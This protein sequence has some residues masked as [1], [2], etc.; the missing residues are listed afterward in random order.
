[1]VLA[2]L[3][4]K[5]KEYPTN[6]KN[7]GVPTDTIIKHF[8]DN[9][10][11]VTRNG[12]DVATDYYIYKVVPEYRRDSD[13]NQYVELTCY[14]YSRDHKLT[15]NPYSKMYVNKKLV[16][17]V[18]TTGTDGIIQTELNGILQK[19]GFDSKTIDCSNLR[20]LKYFTQLEKK[21]DNGNVT[22]QE[23]KKE[24]IQP[25]L[26]QYNES[27][28]DF[29]AR[30][31][32]RCG[33]FLYHDKGKLH[34]GLPVTPSDKI[35][36]IDA[37]KVFAY[38]YQ[39]ISDNIVQPAPVCVDGMDLGDDQKGKGKFASGDAGF[40]YYDELPFDEYLGTVLEKDGFATLVNET[41]GNYRSIAENLSNLLTKPTIGGS[42][43]AVAGGFIVAGLIGKGNYASKNLEGN[44]TYINNAPAEQKD[45]DK[46]RL[47]GSMLSKDV[48]DLNYEHEQNLN[49]K[50][51]QFVS[52]CALN[53]GKELIT[54]DT[55]VTDNKI[56][57]LG[58]EVIFENKNCIVISVE[59]DLMPDENSLNASQGQRLVLVPLYTADVK[60]NSGT[61]E[62]LS[63]FCPPAVVPF[64]REASTQHAFIA[65][66]GDPESYGRVKIRYPWQQESDDPSP[67]IRMAVPFA[68]NNAP[69]GRAGFF[70]EPAVGDEVLVDYENGNIEH[71]IVT[72][73]LYSRR[74]PAPKSW[75]REEIGM[76]SGR[77]RKITSEKGHSITFTDT[78]LGSHFL[79]GFWPGYKMLTTIVGAIPLIGQDIHFGKDDQVS[80]GISLTDKWGMY[81]ISASATDRNITI[82]SP[83]GDVMINAF[84]GI[85]IN[86]PNGDV[87]ISGKN[88]TLEAGNELKLVSGKNIDER[89]RSTGEKWGDFGYAVVVDGVTDSVLAPLTDMRLIRTVF[90]TFKKPIAGTLTVHSCRYLL[91]NAGGGHAEIPN[92]GLTLS[93]I[94]KADETS[95]KKRK[96]IKSL[97]LINKMTDKLMQDYVQLY[98]DIQQIIEAV[99]L[100]PNYPDL[101]APS[102]DN[103]VSEAFSRTEE[104][105]ADDVKFTDGIVV[106]DFVKVVYVNFFNELRKKCSDI[107]NTCDGF[108]QG[109]LLS[110]TENGDTY[111]AKEL[112]KELGS[113]KS[114]DFI[115]D[116]IKKICDK[117]EKFRDAA[118]S[119]ADTDADRKVLRRVLTEKMITDSKVLDRSAVEV[120]KTPKYFSSKADYLSDG[121]WVGYL[122]QLTL[123]EAD[124]YHQFD[125]LGTRFGKWWASLGP[126]IVRT[127][128][129][130]FWDGAWIKE[131]DLWDTCKQGEI[132]MSDKGGKDTVSIVNGALTRTSNEDG[133]IE[134][135]M[136][137]LRTF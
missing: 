123:F 73:S 134:Q 130:D 17:D 32:N 50:F 135:T 62:K 68:P 56:Y 8:K 98:M 52:K 129:H 122:N 113:I 18:K 118:K 88:I 36:T 2:K 125:K 72:G 77:E 116:Y 81:R 82:N 33:E 64:I 15:L 11:K 24:F 91:L 111:F 41:F 131:N 25:Y 27:F 10:L 21:D 70:F 46:V 78:E 94:K 20:F 4:L 103:L 47:Y 5:R 101:T 136:D 105:T 49:A 1:M 109:T 6:Q 55:G 127:L 7:I 38:S 92:S 83:F 30:T 117:S 39:S 22:Q 19:A 45:G 112:K 13:A 75:R 57:S 43:G 85:T 107:Y 53:V 87:K 29:L 65:A 12:S 71:P 67:W 106:E 104:Y 54:V 63:L 86:A 51:Y 95:V 44:E 132:L 31:A 61:A 102:K 137:I 120:I 74:N 89:F 23:K 126:G 76:V 108:L 26:V 100:L 58:E 3:Q 79:T 96:L 35:H 9:V 37:Q 34:I 42:I 128:K 115:P 14:C 16:G 66:N 114:L 99:E 90:E 80:G 93:G 48:Q 40:F 119:L 28:Y 59:E 69:A 97:H 60:T 133:Y 110:N 124:V 84:T 121:K